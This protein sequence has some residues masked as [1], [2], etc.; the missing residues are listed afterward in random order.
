MAMA[1]AMAK[2]MISATQVSGVPQQSN[3]SFTSTSQ[4]QDNARHSGN[5]YSTVVLL[6]ASGLLP[7]VIEIRVFELSLPLL[8]AEIMLS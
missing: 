2:A 4:V 8:L 5:T 3:M 1:M 6:W 7:P